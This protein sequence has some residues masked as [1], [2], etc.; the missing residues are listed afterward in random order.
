ML[1]WGRVERSETTPQVEVMI[2]NQSSEG[3]LQLLCSV[4]GMR[5]LKIW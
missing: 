1:A 2:P 4:S 5:F 3:A